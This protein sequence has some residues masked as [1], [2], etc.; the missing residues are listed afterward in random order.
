MPA[1]RDYIPDEDVAKC[2][3]CRHRIDTDSGGFNNA[4]CRLAPNS[5]GDH[6]RCHTQRRWLDVC[7]INFN[8]WQPI[9]KSKVKRRTVTARIRRFNWLRV[10][11]LKIMCGSYKSLAKRW[12]TTCRLAVQR[13]IFLAEENA[14]HKEALAAIAGGVCENLLDAEQIALD[15]LNKD[16]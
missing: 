16:K 1:Q 8:K 2:M 7:D 11:Y 9:D 13:N 4:K 15:A 10:V 5:Q 3:S 14:K 12:E 6:F